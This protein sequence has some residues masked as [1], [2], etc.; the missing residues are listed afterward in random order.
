MQW[1]M[2]AGAS[3]H[4]SRRNRPRKIAPK[5]KLNRS[6]LTGTHRSHEIKSLVTNR[7]RP[8]KLHKKMCADNEA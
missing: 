1:S 4:C 2:P 6:V 8:E 5:Q 3:P 7:R